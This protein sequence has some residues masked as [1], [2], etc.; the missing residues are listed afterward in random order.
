MLR[1]RHYVEYGVHVVGIAECDKTVVVR[2]ESGEFGFRIHGSRPVVV[3]AIEPDTPAE[4]SGLEVGD[5]II[6]VNS[7]NVLDASHSEVVK[8]AHAGMI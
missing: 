3:S 4:T 8:I 5:I 7:V 2:R 6:S 1:N